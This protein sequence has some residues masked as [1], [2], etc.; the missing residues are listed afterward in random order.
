M[1]MRAGPPCKVD[2]TRRK[3]TCGVRRRVVSYTDR[4]FRLHTGLVT[5]V[6]SS[7][8]RACESPLLYC[9]PACFAL[10]AW[11]MLE[12]LQTRRACVPTVVW[13]RIRKVCFMRIVQTSAGIRITKHFFSRFQLCDVMCVFGLACDFPVLWNLACEA[14]Y[15][16]SNSISR[17]YIL[18]YTVYLLWLGSNPKARVLMP[19][20]ESICFYNVPPSASN[21]LY[22]AIFKYSIHNAWIPKMGVTLSPWVASSRVLNMHRHLCLPMNSA[23]LHV[24]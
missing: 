10:Y 16:P 8:Y 12:Y 1:H 23:I 24:I 9:K 4:S 13:C 5:N 22:H 18:T 2:A 17:S 3:S 19:C 21:S 6:K 11:K 7:A 14:F 15:V 20:G